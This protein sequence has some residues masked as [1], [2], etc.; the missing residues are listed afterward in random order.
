MSLLENFLLSYPEYFA[1]LFCLASFHPCKSTG[2]GVWPKP[3]PLK[4]LTHC[5]NT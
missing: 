4:A 1:L 5:I 3:P 2:A